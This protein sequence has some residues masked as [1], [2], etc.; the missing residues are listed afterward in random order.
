MWRSKPSV[1]FVRG[2]YRTPLGSHRELAPDR[3]QAAITRRA[4]LRW[5]VIGSVATLGLAVSLWFVFLPRSAG[6]HLAQWFGVVTLFGAV[7][8]AAGTRLLTRDRLVSAPLPPPLA[9]V[10]LITVLSGVISASVLIVILGVR[11]VYVAVELVTVVPSADV[12]EFGFGPGGLITWCLLLLACAVGRLSTRDPRL[13][14]CL[15]A[16]GA[17]TGAWACLL[18]PVFYV[19]PHGGLYR[20]WSTTLLC[21][22]LAF[23]LAATALA[24]PRSVVGTSS[25]TVPRP[26]RPTLSTAW[27]GLRMVCGAMATA[28]LV[29]AAYHYAVPLDTASGRWRAPTIMITASAGL[30][31]GACAL[32][33]RRLGG[34]GLCEA[35]MGLASITLGGACVCLLP[36]VPL[37]M[38]E[39]YPMVLNALLIGLALAAGLHTQLARIWRRRLLG[40]GVCETA[41]RWLPHTRHAAFLTAA[42]A[43]TVAGMMAVWPRLRE[44][45]TPDFSLGRVTAGFGGNLLLLLV[46]L[47]AARQ[48]RR[49]TFHILTLLALVST[50]G[51]MLVRMLPYTPRFG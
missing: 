38:A 49:P 40:G 6:E 51:F 19:A 25:A 28:L 36:H 48:W 26:G 11:T 18:A 13:T 8:L 30:G 47:W 5:L 12:P 33:A 9:A 20:T 35:T 41:D 22:W 27:T 34:G 1:S 43:L 37:S 45:G 2:D 15:T 32:L 23:V 31:V 39:R 24:E 3:T 42:A 50:A 4:L 10:Q 7:A 16:G 21:A 29:L 46:F 14:A 44:V 17:A